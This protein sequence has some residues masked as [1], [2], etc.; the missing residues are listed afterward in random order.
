MTEAPPKNP[1][2]APDSPDPHD[3][4]ASP[5]LDAERVELRLL[6][7]FLAVVEELHF[8][9]AAERLHMSQPPLSQA[10]R[11]LEDQLG[12]DLLERGNRG[13]TPTEAGRAFAEEARRVIAGVDVAVAEARRAGGVASRL[14]IGAT[15]N[16]PSLVAL[17]GLV[18]ALDEAG[19]VSNPEVTRLQSLEQVRRLRNGELELGVFPYGEDHAGLEM[20]PI[21]PGEPLAAFVAKDHPASS[22]D[23]LGPADLRGETVFVYQRANPALWE[24]CLERLEG[25]GYRFAHVRDM[26]GSNDGREA[27]LEV[28]RA[29]SG[30]ALLPSS[31]METGQANSISVRVPLD[32]PV[33]MPD[34]MLNWSA[35]PPR[36]LGSIL[37]GARRVARRLYESQAPAKRRRDSAVASEALAA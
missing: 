33:A 4:P 12:V 10:I 7:Y 15:P 26:G 17:H 36:Q 8:G 37:Q 9:H 6:R 25:A 2:P 30:L 29:G 34:T 28:A 32:P 14:R 5:P 19:L 13:V 1:T 3:S 22:R 31:L 18:S 16:L 23:A 20:E 11:K 35:H 24:R 21:F 27:I